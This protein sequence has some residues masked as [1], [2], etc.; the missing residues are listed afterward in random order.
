[1]LSLGSIAEHLAGEGASALRLLNEAQDITAGLDDLPARLA[2]LQAISVDGFFRGDLGAVRSAS[3][4]GAR[5]SRQA[6]DLY[7]LE[8]WLMNLGLA[9]LLTGELDESKQMLEEG[10]RIARQIVDRRLQ[11]VLVGALGC[12]VASSNPRLAARLLGA[13]EK[14]RAEVAA[15]AHPTLAPL[16]TRTVGFLRSALGASRF[17]VEF[18]SGQRLTRSAA[19][20][21]ALGEPVSTA[22]KPPHNAVSGP[23]AT[24]E[25]E[26]A[27]L[28]ADGL[29][30]KQVGARLFISERTVENHV[31]NILNK[32]GFDS[33]TQLAGWMAVSD[34]G[35]R[36]S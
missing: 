6:D 5:L 27:R 36:Q 17:E 31:R 2:L 33:R 34:G 32:M 20:A 14:L 21:L 8:V 3:A 10:L 9:A 4:E 28:V 7:T 11:S 19:L 30:N 23:L 22:G 18:N 25:L 16:V 15:S 13:S 12:R 24:R 35:R 1:S 29:T 26:V